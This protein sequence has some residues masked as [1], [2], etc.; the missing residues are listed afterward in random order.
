[1]L[2]LHLP[3]IGMDTFTLITYIPQPTCEAALAGVVSALSPSMAAAP[4]RQGRR[5]EPYFATVLPLPVVVAAHLQFENAH[6]RF[7]QRFLQAE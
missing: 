4:M 3:A 1:M 5:P 2:S 7:V 6:A